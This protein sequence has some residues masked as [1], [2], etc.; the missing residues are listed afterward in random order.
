M[1]LQNHEKCVLVLKEEIRRKEI[2][3]SAT[4]WTDLEDIMLSEIS[5][6]QEDKHC[7]IPL[8]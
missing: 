2:L 3:T 6:S 7:A 5:Q 1:M 4:V 8:I